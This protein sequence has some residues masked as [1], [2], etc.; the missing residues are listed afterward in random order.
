MTIYVR[1]LKKARR[2]RAFKAWVIAIMCVLGGYL[3]IKGY[4]WAVTFDYCELYF[5]MPCL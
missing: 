5:N 1:K 4:L 3:L 2:Q